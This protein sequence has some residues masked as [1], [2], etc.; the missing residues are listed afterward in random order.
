[1]C[2]IYYKRD[3]NAIL[4]FVFFILIICLVSSCAIH[5]EFPFI[6][7]ASGC[8]KQQFNMKPFKKRMQIAISGRKRRINASLSSSKNKKS[9]PNYPS[10]DI[11]K[12]ETA[13]DSTLKDSVIQQT[14]F[15]VT[16]TV[17]KI[18]YLELTDSV[19][20]K[21]K[22]FIKAFVKRSSI[23]SIAEISL[24]DFFSEDGY[25]DKSIKADIEKYLIDIGISKYRLFWR[26]NKRIKTKEQTTHFKKL[27]YLE[28][29]FQ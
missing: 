9:K 20:R 25:T 23:K 22:A 24:T 7:F 5:K 3:T 26:R 1:M 11:P 4:R 2:Y 15:G 6:C 18:Y 21:H 10:N 16:D 29:R 13:K 28:I 12:I 14:V 27:V 17:I 8:V 19:L